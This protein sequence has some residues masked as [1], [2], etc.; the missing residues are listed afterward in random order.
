[1]YRTFGEFKRRGLARVTLKTDSNNP[2]N[3]WR[4][5]ER[6]G[7]AIERTYEIFQKGSAQAD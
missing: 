6:V 4:L 2:T 3:A 7:M 5:Y 1:M